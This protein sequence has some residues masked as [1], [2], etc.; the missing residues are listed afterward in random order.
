[1]F[2]G[3]VDDEV[4]PRFAIRSAHAP[5]TITAERHIAIRIKLREFE[6]KWR[7]GFFKSAVL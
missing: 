6:N 7:D 1:V 5:T 4:A 2:D 3:P